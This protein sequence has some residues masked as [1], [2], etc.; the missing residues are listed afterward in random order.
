MIKFVFKWVFRLFLL[1]VMLAV[2]CFFSLDSIVRVYMEHSIRA[3]TGMDAEIGRVSIGLLEP[4]LEIRDLKIFNPPSYGGTLL[5]DIPEFHVEYDRL[6]LA[7][8]KIHLTL[9]RLN[10]GELDVVKN[11]AGQTNVFALGLALPT[12]PKKGAGLAVAPRAP[13]IDLGKPMGYSFVSVD[14]LNVSVGT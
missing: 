2:I 5:M 13:T 4:R 12:P 1:V 11:E 8:H 7:E 3:Q 6:A 14:V 9:V 10:L